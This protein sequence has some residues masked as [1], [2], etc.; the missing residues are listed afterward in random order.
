MLL[1]YLLWLSLS[2]LLLSLLLTLSL[3]DDK[4]SHPS[5]GSGARLCLG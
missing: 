3:L 4:R 5:G 2:G 1:L